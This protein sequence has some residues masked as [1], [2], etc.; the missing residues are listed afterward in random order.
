M[1]RI[2]MTTPL[3]MLFVFIQN[4]LQPCDFT[5]DNQVLLGGL[6]FDSRVGYILLEGANALDCVF[7]SLV[8]LPRVRNDLSISMS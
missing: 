6:I 3:E 5:A 8:A 1:A 2:P 4:L 7:L